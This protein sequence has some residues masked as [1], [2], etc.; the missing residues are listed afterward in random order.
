[1]N[2]RVC[3][4]AVPG[5]V[6]CLAA[7]SDGERLLSGS[8]D[9][10]IRLW[11]STTGAWSEVA[12]LF[13][14]AGGVN[15]VV[16][17]AD[18]RRAFSGGMDG[19][20]R[21]WNL[22]SPGLE[23]TLHGHRQNVIDL[24]LVDDQTVVSIGSDHA[25]KVWKPD[26]LAPA[27]VSG[28]PLAIVRAGATGGPADE[29][30]GSAEAEYAFL[31]PRL[32][33]DQELPAFASLEAR[34]APFGLLTAACGPD[35]TVLLIDTLTHA[36][37][38]VL[39]GRLENGH[40]VVF[41]T[42]RDGTRL[43]GC[44]GENTCRLWDLVEK[45]FVAQWTDKVH[46]SGALAFD[47]VGR[48]IAVPS[49]PSEVRV[50]DLPSTEIRQTLVGHGSEVLA[51]AFS[52]DDSLIATGSLD[53]TVRLWDARTGSTLHVLSGHALGIESVA[54]SPD[55][56]R[57]ASGD[58]LGVVRLW[59][60]ASGQP[61]GVLRQT[62]DPIH[63]LAFLPDG[64]ALGAWSSSKGLR[65]WYGATPAE[66]LVD[67]LLEQLVSPEDVAT[68]IESD[69]SLAPELRS[70]AAHLAR[71]RHADPVRLNEQ[72]WNLA[73]IAGRTR[74]EYQEAVRLARGACALSSDNGYYLN[75]LGAAEYRSGDYEAALDPLTHADRVNHGLPPDL[76]F[77]A[78]A[79]AG[80]GRK[81]AALGALARMRTL[82]TDAG[83][84]GGSPEVLALEAERV[85]A[86]SWPE[87]APHPEGVGAERR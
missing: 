18:G 3:V 1:M 81:E 35:G 24:A 74:G 48:R 33:W 52:P 84:R 30:R 15:A 58:Q 51:I 25:V 22:A 44:N 19:S 65:F 2:A 46:T 39:E 72:A 23:A 85:V 45:W 71:E 68:E 40:G 83:W 5:Q 37:A 43:A 80:L 32:T 66:Q 50:R 7:T 79:N 29:I 82:M 54:F 63:D 36:P 6:L 14:H 11:R 8:N 38:S 16:V 60:V 67:R 77:I 21:V 69:P 4:P 64:S 76:A 78:M 53:L 28:G 20:I 73:A 12:T 87:V 70:R 75:T 62:S 31:R 13:G 49:P 27:S 9:G 61:V 59:D 57:L 42:S 47:S 26:Q 86:A 56:T 34:A 55:G 17:R 10:T 41:S